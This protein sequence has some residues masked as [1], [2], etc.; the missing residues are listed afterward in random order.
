MIEYK[1]SMMPTFTDLIGYAATVVGTCFM[2]PQIAK[3]WK[4]RSVSDLSMGMVVLFF[5]NCILWLSYGI[6]ISAMPVIIANGI[7]LVISIVQSI[8]KLKYR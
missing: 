3:S 1:K 8:L 6:L 5:F 4:T 7:G 2:L